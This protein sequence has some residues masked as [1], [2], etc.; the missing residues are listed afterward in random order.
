M[1]TLDHAFN[2]DGLR[3]S[4]PKLKKGVKIRA[5]LGWVPTRNGR[6]QKQHGRCRA[7]PKERKR[8]V[9]ECH[10]THSPMIRRLQIQKPVM[11]YWK[12]K[13]DG[14]TREGTLTS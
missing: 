9:H 6:E 7:C 3:K 14:R 8:G 2:V 13:R 1:K 4:G 5:N 12:V 11:T 10:S